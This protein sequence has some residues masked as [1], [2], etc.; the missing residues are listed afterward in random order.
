MDYKKIGNRYY[1]KENEVVLKA[2]FKE[3]EQEYVEC[4]QWTIEVFL[5]H[6]SPFDGNTEEQYAEIVKE[7]SLEVV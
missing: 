1:K 2:T 5:A 4:G 3:E 7:L 6:A